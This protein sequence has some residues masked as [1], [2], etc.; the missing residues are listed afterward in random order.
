MSTQPFP[1]FYKVLGRNGQHQI[2]AWT[3]IILINKDAGKTN[4][5]EGGG[6]RER[7]GLKV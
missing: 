4:A 6:E 7:I 5:A 2:R 1:P 3:L